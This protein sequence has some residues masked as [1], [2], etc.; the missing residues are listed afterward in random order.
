[1][2]IRTIVMKVDDVRESAKFWQAFIGAAPLKDFEGW[3]EFMIAGVRFAIMKR[4]DG[5][6]VGVNNCVPVFELRE[7]EISAYVERAKSLG[8]TVLVDG[9]EDPE[10]LSI[11]MQDPSGNEFEMSKPQI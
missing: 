5:Q 6:A 10:M 11:A 2:K 3:V 9:L 1:M 8:A 4:D 7:T